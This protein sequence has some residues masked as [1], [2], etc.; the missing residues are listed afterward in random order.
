MVCG[1]LIGS[2]KAQ[3]TIKDT[4]KIEE[5]VVTGSPVRINRDNV[6]MSVSVVTSAQINESSESAVLPVL[7]G[8]IPGLFVTERGITGFG[9]S[10][11]SAGQITIR[12]IGGSPTTGVLML[13]D[14]H[15]QF[16]GIMG[17][18]LPD[19]YVASDIERVEVIRGSGSVLY[20]SN[21]MGGVINLITKKQ[22]QDGFHGNARLMYGSYNTQKYMASGG[23]KKDKLSVFVSGNRDK[24]DGH[25]ANSAFE[26]ANGYTLK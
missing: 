19:S 11:G 1:S 22:T 17:H 6:P 18:P 9:V 8:C 16:M 26:I 23:Y 13:I 4:V 7:S 3:D 21:A 24:T 14:G 10:A 25:R 15:P 5:V 20:G 12:G 2:L